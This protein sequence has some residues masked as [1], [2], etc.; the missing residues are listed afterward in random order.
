M[1]SSRTRFEN[2]AK[3][4]SEMAFSPNRHQYVSLEFDIKV[5]FISWLIFSFF[6]ITFQL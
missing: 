2:E 3:G 1:I 5:G 4:N 6:L